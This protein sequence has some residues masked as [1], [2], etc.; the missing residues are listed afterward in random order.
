[1]ASLR[2]L[3][4]PGTLTTLR[5]QLNTRLAIVDAAL[6]ANGLRAEQAGTSIPFRVIYFGG[7]EEAISSAGTL[8]EEADC[9]TT[10]VYHPTIARGAGAIRISISVGHAVEDIHKLMGALLAL[11]D[12]RKVS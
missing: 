6:A 11:I 3:A 9:L 8:L 12:R 7:P 1:M 4:R 10:P 5:A 2:I